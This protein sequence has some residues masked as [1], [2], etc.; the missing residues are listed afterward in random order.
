MDI[1]LDDLMEDCGQCGGTGKR[2]PPPSAQLNTSYGPHSHVMTASDKC[3]S[4]RGSGK[5][6][7]TPSGQAIL[8]LIKHSKGHGFS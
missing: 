3:E 2:Q 4:C 6:K 5:Y 1:T 8:D 7:P